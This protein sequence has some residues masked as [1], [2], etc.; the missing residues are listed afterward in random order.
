MLVQQLPSSNSS[1][2]QN[3]LV[4]QLAVRAI[5]GSHDIVSCNDDAMFITCIKS[6]ERLIDGKQVLFKNCRNSSPY[7]L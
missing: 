5:E 1:T 2:L 6:C 7:T 3:L 4:V